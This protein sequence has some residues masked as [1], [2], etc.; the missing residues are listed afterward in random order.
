MNN[1]DPPEPAVAEIAGFYQNTVDTIGKYIVGNRQALD[2][3][4]TALLAE[5]HVLVQG[6]PGTGK[7]SIAKAIAFITG[8]EFNRIQ[9]TIDVQPT[10]MIGVRIYDNAIK[11]FTMQKGPIF[12]NLLL[13]DEI[14]R[15]NPK[16][17]S[18]FIEAMS[19]RQVTIDGITTP[20]SSPFFVIATQNPREFEGTFPLIEVQ[21]DR[22]MFSLSTEHLLGDEELMVVR[23][24]SQGLLSWNEFEFF[25]KPVTARDR[26][27]RM[28]DTVSTIRMEEP[29]LTY[30]RDLVIAT[31][32]HSDIDLGASSRAS[33][34]FVKGAKAR[35]ACAG[36]S[37]ALPD[38]VK[39]I[40]PSVLVH[41]INL[42]SEAEVEG[43][44]RGDIVQEILKNTEVP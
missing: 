44:S 40:A 10:D 23:R 36:R 32:H 20:L 12:T 41:R 21:R 15:I 7:T 11:K 3:I 30:I 29:V 18:A 1:Q 2:I 33:I 39:A 42:T 6:V 5:G 16:A 28:I 43:I 38:D 27:A 9:G 13:V 26:L 31:R 4:L 24:A 19:E 14:N 34:A 37:Y 35:A 17:Q 8:C 25:L 22:F